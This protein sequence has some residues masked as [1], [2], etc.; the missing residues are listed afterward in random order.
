M[1]V[2]KER[3]PWPK[4]GRR[5]DGPISFTSV[6]KTQTEPGVIWTLKESLGA[7]HAVCWQP[8]RSKKADYRKNLNAVDS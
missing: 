4:N 1:Q 8:N 6:Q 2:L 7:V 5:S 3:N